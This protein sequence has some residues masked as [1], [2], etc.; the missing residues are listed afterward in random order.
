MMVVPG[1]EHQPLQRR[2]V[3]ADEESKNESRI[4]HES[5]Y[6]PSCKGVRAMNR[7]LSP[8]DLWAALPHSAST[9][10]LGE[11]SFAP[12]ACSSLSSV[13]RPASLCDLCG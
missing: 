11:R 3:R 13:L 9:Q 7:R 10:D 4:E 5:A 6:G 1:R 8:K 2:S 12:T